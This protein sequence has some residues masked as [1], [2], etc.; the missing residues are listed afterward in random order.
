MHDGVPRPV[1]VNPRYTASME[2]LEH[3]FGMGMLARHARA[4]GAAPGTPGP[5]D[6]FS[7]RPLW[8]A[9]AIFFAKEDLIFPHSGPWLAASGSPLPHGIP[10]AFADI[11]LP[12]ERISA[13]CPVLTY[14][15]ALFV[16]GNFSV[17]TLRI[18]TLWLAWANQ[19]SVIR[20]ILIYT[21]VFGVLE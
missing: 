5:W 10:P 3:A 11:P 4:L 8:L 19:R 9:K 17:K 21:L 20:Q 2:V 18:S 14:L 7:L 12:G 1:E 6:P 15:S 13:G 16:I